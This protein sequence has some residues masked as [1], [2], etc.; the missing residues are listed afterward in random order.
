VPPTGL[1]KLPKLA[2]YSSGADSPSRPARRVRKATGIGLPRSTLGAPVEP[3]QM[4]RSRCHGVAW[5]IGMDVILNS[6]RSSPHCSAM[7]IAENVTANT[8]DTYR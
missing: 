2:M 1:V 8:P 5:S 4:T 6:P 3:T 7:S